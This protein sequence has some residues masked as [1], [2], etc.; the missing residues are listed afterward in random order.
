MVRHPF[1]ILEPFRILTVVAEDLPL[2]VSRETLQT[3]TFM[4]QIKQALLKRILMLFNRILE[5]DEEK[6]KELIKSYGTAL[7]L[8]A[9]E[10]RK[11]QIKLASL[12]RFHTNQRNM[13]S[14]DDVST[15]SPTVCSIPC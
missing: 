11:N 8:G 10:D 13:T 1:I 4:R 12:V 5:E 6:F 3:T 2:N 14:L 9:V 15:K 7:K